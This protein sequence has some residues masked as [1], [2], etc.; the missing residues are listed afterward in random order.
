M[1]GLTINGF[2]DYD[3]IPN[4]DEKIKQTTAPHIGENHTI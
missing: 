1:L 4:V 2:V 3:G